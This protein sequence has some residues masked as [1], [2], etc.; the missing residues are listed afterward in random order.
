MTG[1]NADP[2]VR[3]T[4]LDQTGAKSVQAIIA[5]GVTVR[6]ILPNIVAKMNLPMEGPD[7]NPLTYSLDH[8]EGGRRL[9]EDQ[10]LEE[11]GVKA[12]DRLVVCPE[13]VAGRSHAEA[14]KGGF[15]DSAPGPGR[16]NIDAHRRETCFAET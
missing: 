5:P 13:V 12:G 14:G 11:A 6:K 2:G 15:V 10:T 9:L 3:V 16:G 8:R 7:G 4:F 1:S